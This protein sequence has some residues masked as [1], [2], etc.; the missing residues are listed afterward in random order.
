[1]T[2]RRSREVRSENTVH[3]MDEVVAADGEAVAITADL[4]YGEV[5]I[6][7]LAACGDGSSTSVYGVHA[8]CGHV[9]W[10]T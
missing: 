9:V 4:P 2:W 1:M 3:G 7:H 6:R 5:W 8:V 10:Q